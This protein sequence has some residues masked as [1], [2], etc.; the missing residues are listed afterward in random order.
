MAF[1]PKDAFSVARDIAA[2]AV[3]KASDIVEDAG[4]I[5]RGNIVGGTSAIVDDSMAIGAYA[6]D[7]VKDAFVGADDDIPGTH[8]DQD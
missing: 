5:V 6:V 3:E 8:D 1:T 7:R 2:N 4:H